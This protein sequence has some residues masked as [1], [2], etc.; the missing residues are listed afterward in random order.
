MGTGRSGRVV[1]GAGEAERV[2]TTGSTARVRVS[3]CSRF[4]SLRKCVSMHEDR[5]E[6]RRHSGGMV[7][8]TG[9]RSAMVRRGRGRE[10][11]RGWMA[12]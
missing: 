3:H 5:I 4:Q 2:L 12:G 1:A 11:K 7:R 10:S 8:K 6:S 9:R